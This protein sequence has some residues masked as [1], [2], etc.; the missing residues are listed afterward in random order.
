MSSKLLGKI[1]PASNPKQCV[2]GIPK[3]NMYVEEQWGAKKGRETVCMRVHEEVDKTHDKRK[4]A[5]RSFFVCDLGASCRSVAR[6]GSVTEAAS[7]RLANLPVESTAGKNR[8]T[9]VRHCSMTALL[10]TVVDTR[11]WHSYLT[12]LQETLTWRS[13]CDALTGRSCGT[14]WLNSLVGHSGLTL[15]WDA[16]TRHSCR[17][18]F[19]DTLVRHS[20]RTLVL[21]ITWHSC[22]RL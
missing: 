16:L 11:T 6:L 5:A 12:V 3:G 9:C 20:C 21:V 7:E 10:D 14:L 4:A 8:N 22:R 2:G 19:P 1:I 15:L 17:T 13:L 18:L